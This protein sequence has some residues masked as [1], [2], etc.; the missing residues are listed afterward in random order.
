MTDKKP[1]TDK[2]N[3]H[4][5]TLEMVKA[6][7]SFIQKNGLTVRDVGIQHAKNRASLANAERQYG[8]GSEQYEA[9]RIAHNKHRHKHATVFKHV[10]ILQRNKSKI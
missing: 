6:A 4:G 9:A 8:V 1:K 10:K 7:R 2:L 3:H 5:D